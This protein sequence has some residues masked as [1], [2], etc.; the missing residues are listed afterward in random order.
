MN[1]SNGWLPQEAIRIKR[2]GGALDGD[3]LQA[4][5]RRHRRRH[6]RRRPGRR[7]RDGG[8]VPRHVAG[9]VRG[10]HARDAGFGRGLQLGALR[11]ARPGARQALDRR[12]RRPRVAGARAD[13]R[14]L[15]RLGAD[16]RRPRPRA[17]R[18]HARQARIDSRIPVAAGAR[19]RAARVEGRGRRDRR[20]GRAHR[21]RRPAA[22][23]HPRRDRDGRLHPVDRRVDPVEETFRRPRCAGARRQEGRRR[24]AAGSRPR[25]RTRARDRRH[26]GGGGTAGRR[27]PDRHERAARAIRGQCA[28]AARGDRR[29]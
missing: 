17:H 9:R 14:R 1:A 3:D 5:R 25:A 23:C 11:G 29:C 20:R 6:D 8:S 24:G 22:L 27:L 10:V 2:D 7:V 21:A 12:H 15:R 4:T 26:R 13:A 18:R 28:G 16:D 19:T